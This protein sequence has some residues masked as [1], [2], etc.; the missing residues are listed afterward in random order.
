MN[1]GI[2]IGGPFDGKELDAKTFLLSIP[3]LEGYTGNGKAVFGAAL[4]H[5]NGFNWIFGEATKH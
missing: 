4:Y 1:K 3:V 5:W 2:A